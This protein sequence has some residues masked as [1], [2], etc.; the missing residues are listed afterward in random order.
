MRITAILEGM[1]CSLIEISKT[2]PR[3]HGVTF[4]KMKIFT[5]ISVVTWDL[6]I[7]IVAIPSIGC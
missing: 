1:L 5:V 6:A 7:R 4:Q 3:L 2:L